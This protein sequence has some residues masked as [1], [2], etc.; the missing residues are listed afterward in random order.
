MCIVENKSGVSYIGNYEYVY[1]VVA[2]LPCNILH[3]W[4]SRRGDNKLVMLGRV[5][6]QVWNGNEML[7]FLTDTLPDRCVNFKYE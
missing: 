3:L 6:C 5:I 2:E 1:S 7:H 4:F